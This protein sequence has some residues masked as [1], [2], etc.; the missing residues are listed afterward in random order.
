MASASELSRLQ[1]G[2]ANE[3]HVSHDQRKS[4]QREHLERAKLGRGTARSK[5]SAAERKPCSY[6]DSALLSQERTRADTF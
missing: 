1:P 3:P 6:F 2:V 5:R 4:V